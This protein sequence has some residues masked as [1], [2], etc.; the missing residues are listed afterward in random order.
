MDVMASRPGRP[1]RGRY[2]V[3]R[4]ALERR[5]GAADYE[6]RLAFLRQIKAALNRQVPPWCPPLFEVILTTG[7]FRIHRRSVPNFVE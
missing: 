3:E 6:S 4:K 1:G 7:R 5:R 2:K